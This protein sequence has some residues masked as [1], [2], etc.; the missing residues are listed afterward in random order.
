VLDYGTVAQP[1]LDPFNPWLGK[2]L[3][4]VLDILS[5]FDMPLPLPYL[6]SLEMYSTD[7]NEQ[8]SAKQ[9]LERLPLFPLTN[10]SP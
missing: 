8:A 5:V 6:A 7:L 4:V 2:T 1:Y 9:P 3:V 10:A